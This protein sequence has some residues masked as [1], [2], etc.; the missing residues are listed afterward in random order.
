[1]KF[2]LP[3]LLC[4]GS[5]LIV[6]I[7]PTRP[8]TTHVCF[9]VDRSG[10]MHGQ[11]F[12]DAIGAFRQVSEQPID[13]LE[14]S[15]IAF[16][17]ITAR[18]PGLDGSGWAELP[19]LEAMEAASG[20]LEA[21]GA[22]GDT[23]VTPALMEALRLDRK[24]LSIVLVSDGLFGRELSHHIL[25]AVA[26]AQ[27]ER[28]QKGLDPALIAVYQVGG[29]KTKLLEALGREGGYLRLEPPPQLPI[30]NFGPY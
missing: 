9:V 11:D 19:S 30:P 21:L 18:W 28:I 22:G 17:D 23:L 1:M 4:L 25:G 3:L 24:E 7:E 29:Y 5:T 2:L 13:E 8:L 14:I 15:V 10:S 26:G 16:T 20:W 27:Q 12:T 6:E